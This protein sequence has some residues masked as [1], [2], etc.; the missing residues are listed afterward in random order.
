MIRVRITIHVQ[1]K[2][3]GVVVTLR[4]VS[5]NW[6]RYLPKQKHEIAGALLAVDSR[7]E[8]REVFSGSRDGWTDQ[9]WATD[10]LRYGQRLG[11]KTG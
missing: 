7:T 3:Q 9:V 8:V 5:T 4:S 2:F 1:K 11:L 10:D 6:R